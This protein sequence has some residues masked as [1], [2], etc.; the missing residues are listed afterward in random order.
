MCESGPEVFIRRLRRL[1]RPGPPSLRDDM[2]P[3]WRIA[4]RSAIWFRGEPPT[5]ASRGYSLAVSAGKSV[6]YEGRPCAYLAQG[7]D[8]A[9]RNPGIII[10]LRVFSAREIPYGFIPGIGVS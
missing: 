10:C 4:A 5:P 2:P 6:S 1:T 3:I 8:R 9:R 7:E